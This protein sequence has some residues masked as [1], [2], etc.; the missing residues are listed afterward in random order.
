MNSVEKSIEEIEKMIQTL[1]A[2]ADSNE[3][4]LSNLRMAYMG[5]DGL[6]QRHKDQIDEVCADIGKSMSAAISSAQSASVKLTFLKAKLEEYLS[7]T[8]G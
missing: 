3:E 1:N 6:D 7:V 2:C 4:A 8:I 5:I